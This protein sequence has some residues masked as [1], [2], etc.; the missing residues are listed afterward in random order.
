MDG[1]HRI[2]V[3]VQEEEEEPIEWHDE[4]ED[5]S[6]HD[7]RS[8]ADEYNIKDGG[9]NVGWVQ[10][11][12]TFNDTATAS[13]RNNNDNNSTT[14][15]LLS[16]VVTDME[17]TVEFVDDNDHDNNNSSVP[18]QKRNEH[19]NC[20]DAALVSF[21]TLGQVAIAFICLLLIGIIIIII[22]MPVLSVVNKPNASLVLNETNVSRGFKFHLPEYTR[23]V[24][25][26]DQEDRE[27]LFYRPQTL[28][29]NWMLQDPF[30][31]DYSADRQVQRFAMFT[32]FSS[33]KTF[34]LLCT[35]MAAYDVSECD[36][37]VFSEYPCSI[38]CGDNITTLDPNN[39]VDMKDEEDPSKLPSLTRNNIFNQTKRDLL[40]RRRLQQDDTNSWHILALRLARNDLR[41]SIPP[42]VALLTDLQVMDLSENEI[43][44]DIP[45]E[46]FSELTRMQYF[47]MSHNVFWT[48][49]TIPSEIGLWS[50]MAHLDLSRSGLDG[51][52]PPQLMSLPKLETL[53]LSDN[54]LTGT[55]DSRI[56]TIQ[57]LKRIELN[58][59]RLEGTLPTELGLLTDMEELLLDSNKFSSSIPTELGDLDALRTIGMANNK[60]T[61][62]IP[63]ELGLLSNL[64]ELWLY[65]N[66][67]TGTVPRELDSLAAEH[68]LSTFILNHNTE[69]SGELSAAVCSMRALQFI[70]A[71]DYGH[72][73]DCQ[74]FL[75]HTAIIMDFHHTSI[76]MDT[77]AMPTP[78]SEFEAGPSFQPTVS[79]TNAPL[80]TIPPTGNGTVRP[81]GNSTS[82]LLDD[83]DSD[84]QIDYEEQTAQTALR[85]RGEDNR[86]LCGF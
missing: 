18:K 33:L 28:A 77:T 46:L 38:Q 51:T 4:D 60:L 45:K 54:Y 80:E 56:G 9:R 61:G 40:R 1:H 58:N 41:G 7:P 70:C 6:I 67:L 69:L 48:L 5:E 27:M 86:F 13:D 79:P 64:E 47:N 81:A 76:I 16:A 3:V 84:F 15:P 26:E 50:R 29:Y 30:L 8:A 36:W 21:L 49:E 72:C 19:K 74:C 57:S 2:G 10:K 63:S 17:D 22:L 71:H 73:C 42:E 66:M 62:P 11:S 20:C 44:R 39:M 12:V 23:K 68:T 59:N 32:L 53:D 65:V 34:G 43:D 24:I 37:D 52:I 85:T 14:D 55:L 75:H 25:E 78:T 83:D 82:S 35:Q 31:D